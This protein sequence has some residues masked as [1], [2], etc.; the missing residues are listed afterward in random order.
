MTAMA[1]QCHVEEPGQER[2]AEDEHDD[3]AAGSPSRPCRTALLRPR[4]IRSRSG[5]RSEGADGG[6]DSD[7]LSHWVGHWLSH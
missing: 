1:A 6:G 4:C 3:A 5:G 2:C 7:G